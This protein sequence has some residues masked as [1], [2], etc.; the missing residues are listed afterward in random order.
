MCNKGILHVHKAD[1]R[2][3]EHQ[4]YV[5]NFTVPVLRNDELGLS[6]IIRILGKGLVV[7]PVYKQDHICIL[8]DGSRLSQVAQQRTAVGPLPVYGSSVQL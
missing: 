4:V 5:C 1:F 3:A 2:L 7:S 8:L 6:G